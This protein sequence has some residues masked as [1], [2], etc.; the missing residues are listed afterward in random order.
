MASLRVLT[1]LIYLSIL[2]R[3]VKRGPE[4]F[5]SRIRISP[6]LQ[7]HRHHL[8]VPTGTGYVE[9]QSKKEDNTVIGGLRTLKTVSKAHQE[10]FLPE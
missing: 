1:A 3:Q 7:Q 6:F 9:L 10:P 5:V 8:S 2:R 4:A